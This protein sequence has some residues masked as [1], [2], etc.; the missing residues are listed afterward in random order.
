MSNSIDFSSL[1]DKIPDSVK[2]GYATLDGSYN[3]HN[4]NKVE[5]A[6]FVTD[7]QG[8]HIMIVDEGGRYEVLQQRIHNYLSSTYSFL[9]NIETILHDLGGDR[10]DR[11]KKK[12]KNNKH[13]KRV[14]GLRNYSQ[15]QRPI[16]L[17]FK[18]NDNDEIE[19]ILIDYE[20]MEEQS[21]LS[22]KE[23]KSMLNIDSE[24]GE[25]LS[26]GMAV[27]NFESKV[28]EELVEWIKDEMS[29]EGPKN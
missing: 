5:L 21:D 24:K 8:I 19:K 22:R 26:L 18:L 2:R 9:D 25:E 28:F 14:L 15:H 11:Y 23:T 20:L 16:P 17:D 27:H 13:N 10:Y 1:F 3:T 12:F 7:L 6:E 29:K 4:L